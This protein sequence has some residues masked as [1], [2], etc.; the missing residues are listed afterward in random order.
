MLVYG[1]HECFIM[2]MLYVCILCASCDISQCCILHDL[3]F[4]NARRGC[5]R[6]SYGIGI[7]QS[8]SPDSFIGSHAC[9]LLFTPSC[10]VSAFIICSGLCA[11]TEM[12]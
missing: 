8:R 6:R 4:V 11:C 9:L 10:C 3:Q 7:L 5:K 1:K 2:R 12:L